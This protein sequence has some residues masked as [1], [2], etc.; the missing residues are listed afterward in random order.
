M[1]PV[2]KGAVLPIMLTHSV[3]PLGAESGAEEEKEV[4]SERHSGDE[5]GMD[6]RQRPA[7]DDL[8]LRR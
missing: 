8:C 3:F 6:R 1:S 2:I 7:P 4:Y 5:R